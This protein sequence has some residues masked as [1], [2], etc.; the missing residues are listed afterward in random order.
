MLAVLAS[1]ATRIA[2]IPTVGEGFRI[3][4][5]FRIV[6]YFPSWSGDPATVQYRALTHVCYAFGAPTKE[7]GYEPIQREAVLADLTA[8]AHAEGVKVFLSFGGW[9]D[10]GPNAYTAIASDPALTA[11]FLDGVME[12]VGRLGLDGIDVDWEFP[13]E[14]SAGIFADLMHALSTRL[15]AAGKELSIAVAATD[16]RGRFYRDSIIADVDF[17]NIMAY[18]DGYGLGPEVNHSA[19][20]FARESLDYWLGRRGVPREKAVL[21]VPFYGR[22]LKDRGAVTFSY[23]RGRD[24]RAAA[25]DVSQGYGYNGFDTLRAKAVNQARVRAG[26]IMIWQLSQDAEGTDSLLNAI[27]DAVK[28][29]VVTR[30]A[31][32]EPASAPYVPEVGEP[33]MRPGAAGPDWTAAEPV[34]P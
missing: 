2:Y 34:A 13:K 22:S 18:D 9:N 3:P 33:P 16:V 27:Y 26:G 5:G 6:G 19:Y 4:A 7:G 20:W 10:G 32:T 14:D 8:R 23:L 15:H 24:D 25:S 11:A 17:L 21:G 12:L 28:E 29:P 31:G 30:P 1:C